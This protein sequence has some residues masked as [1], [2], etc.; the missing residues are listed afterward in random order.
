MLKS[1]SSITPTLLCRFLNPELLNEVV[2]AQSNAAD[3]SEEDTGVPKDIGVSL[4]VLFTIEH[5]GPEYSCVFDSLLRALSHSDAFLEKNA[6]N[7]E[8]SIVFI[9]VGSSSFAD[10]GA[11][12]TVPSDDK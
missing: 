7:L 2:D 4:E 10:R 11:S 6:E 5:N 9:N 3:N 1:S 8:H 12:S